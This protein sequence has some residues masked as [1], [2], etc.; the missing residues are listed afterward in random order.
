MP[1]AQGLGNRINTSQWKPLWSLPTGLK[2]YP[3]PP[4]PPPPLIFSLFLLNT[5]FFF[6]TYCSVYAIP[7]SPPLCSSFRMRY[8]TS[9]YISSATLDSFSH[10]NFLFLLLS[11]FSSIPP[12]QCAWGFSSSLYIPPTSG[13]STDTHTHTHTHTTL[14][15]FPPPSIPG[16]EVSFLIQDTKQTEPLYLLTKTQTVKVP[17]RSF[18]RLL[19]PPLTHCRP[20]SSSL[21]ASSQS[22]TLFSSLLCSFSL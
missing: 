16:R 15:L 1:V 13:G 17:Q 19:P 5:P 14:Y 2:L 6:H 21:L 4:R 3:A 9:H 10:C 20:V 11:L 8:F 22:P 12:G 7:P 18:L